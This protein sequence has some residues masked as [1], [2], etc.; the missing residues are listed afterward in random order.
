MKPNRFRQV[1][2]A[3]GQPA[4]HM[5]MEFGTRGIA[6]IL[7]AADPDF[8]VFDMEHS[9]FGMDRIYDLL[10]WSKAC[11]FTPIV[12]VPQGRYHFLARVM[13]AGA[14]GVMVGNVETAEEAAEIVAC[15]KYPPQGK[16][17]VGLGTA[18]NDYVFPRSAA[19]YLAEANSTGLVI[20]QIESEVGVSNAE[21][22]AATPGVDCLWIGHFDLSSSMGIPG[23]F[24]DERFQRARAEVVLAAK[25][26]GKLL[27]IQPGNAEMAAEWRAAGFNVFSWGSD[28]AVFR[29]ALE[30]GIRTLRQ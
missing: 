6:K 8:V 18:H 16:R 24:G 17:G 29:T 25:L 20:C 23:Q 10:A 3:G 9:G 11:P 14:T 1:V 12:R 13:D 5:V 22:I 21:A 19:E 30:A 27:G 26:H 7:E 4:G 28:V 15:V 2:Q